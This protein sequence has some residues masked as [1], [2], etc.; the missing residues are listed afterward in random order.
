MFEKIVLGVVVG[1]CG[2]RGSVVV[3]AS[4]APFLGTAASRCASCARNTRAVCVLSVIVLIG[5]R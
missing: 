5:W 4:R 3:V 1:G 2:E